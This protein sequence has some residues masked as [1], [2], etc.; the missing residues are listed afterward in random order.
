M[1]VFWVK[2]RVFDGRYIGNEFILYD[3][4]ILSYCKNK[5]YLG[6]NVLSN[7][8]LSVI[9]RV[10]LVPQVN[11]VFLVITSWTLLVSELFDSPKNMLSIWSISSPS[12]QLFFY[13]SYSSQGR[14]YINTLCFFPE[15]S[16]DRFGIW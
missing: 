7:S 13:S 16:K 2:G 5:N 12:P 14:S 11:D 1:C 4:H 3:G 9:Y 6:I 8:S 10:L 15:A